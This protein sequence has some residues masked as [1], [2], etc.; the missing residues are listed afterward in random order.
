MSDEEQ[1]EEGEK[2]GLGK[3]PSALGKITTAGYASLDLIRYFTCEYLSSLFLTFTLLDGRLFRS[4][5]RPDRSWFQRYH[6]LI[7]SVGVVEP[8]G[9]WNKSPSSQ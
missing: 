4:W 2:I 3:K 5:C 1:A 9:W 8:W 6:C 7:T